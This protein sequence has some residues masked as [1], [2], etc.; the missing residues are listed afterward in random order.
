M[1]VRFKYSHSFFTNRTLFSAVHGAGI[2]M[3]CVVS[4]LSVSTFN[5]HA[6]MQGLREIQTSRDVDSYFIQVAR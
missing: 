5:I 6:D 3:K 4:T 2:L 1:D